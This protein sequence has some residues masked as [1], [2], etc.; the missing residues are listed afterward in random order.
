[1]NLM[2]IDRIKRSLMDSGVGLPSAIQRELVALPYLHRLPTLH[3][4]YWQLT[5]GRLSQ[6]WL[7]WKSC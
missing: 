2:Q 3:S 5:Q 7:S 6:S 1:V 4:R